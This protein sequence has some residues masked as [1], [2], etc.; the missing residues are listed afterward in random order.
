MGYRSPAD[1]RSGSPQQGVGRVA[2]RLARLNERRLEVKPI[3]IGMWTQVIGPMNGGQFDITPD[4]NWIYFHGADP[5]GKGGLFR[6]ATSGGP[7]ERLG[8][9]PVQSASGTLR[10]SPD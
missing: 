6:V 7:P 4:G 10:L 2:D 3:S 1:N 8:D 5:Y 9:F